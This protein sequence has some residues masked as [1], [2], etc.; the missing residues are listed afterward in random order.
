MP[1][2]SVLPARDPSKRKTGLRRFA[3]SDLSAPQLLVGSFAL[4]I[5]S[6][7]LGFAVLPGLWIGP[8]PGFVDALFMATSAVCV[9]GLSVVDV[10]SQL[11]FF[12]QLWLLLLI[13]LGGL[14]ILTIAALAAAALGRRTSLEVEEAAAGPSNLLPEAGPRALVRAVI[15]A[16][17]VIEAIGAVSLWITWMPSLGAA[18][19]VWPAVF[20]AI[21]AFCNAGFSIF[22]NG[23]AGHA[24]H[25]PTLGIVAALLLL[26]GIGFLVM[27]DLRANVRGRRRRVTLHTRIVLVTSG[28]LIAVALPLFLFF[29]WDHTLADMSLPVRIANAFFM[30]VTPRTAGFNTVDYE[31]IA[32]PSVFLTV[33]LM[34]IGGSPGSTAG[35]IKTTT[36]ALLALGLWARLRGRSDVSLANRSIPEATLQRATGLA[37]GA[38]LVLFAFVFALLW[39]EL[40]R[41]GVDTDRGRF[42][43]LVF[44]AQSAL[45]TVGLSMN[46]TSELTPAGRLLIVAL[47]FMGRV[48]PLALLESMARRSRRKQP[49]RLGREDILVG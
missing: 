23:L 30:A 26:G 34:Y 33:A 6:G 12:G 44:E 17:L 14:G 27:E 36:A 25:L 48:G 11:T 24:T 28:I 1:A 20:H 32:N 39:T 4:L 15:A 47:M 38:I 19:A 41:E 46:M 35:G 42:V 31:Q 22:A 2:M 9:T 10:S 43:R 45:G 37:V 7:T 21:S 8:R 13:Q 3:P 29:E 18:G 5:A 40:E 16:T 49:Y